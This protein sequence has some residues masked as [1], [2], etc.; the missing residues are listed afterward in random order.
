MI[1]AVN[2]MVLPKTGTVFNNSTIVAGST[3]GPMRSVNFEDVLDQT[4]EKEDTQIKQEDE[5]DNMNLSDYTTKNTST[6]SLTSELEDIFIRASQKYNVP[7]N[8]LKAVGKQESNFQNSAVSHAGAQGIM[9]LMP[10][11][12]QYLGVTD[13]FDPEQNIMGGAKYLSQMLEKFDNDVV[14]AL[15][16]YNAGPGSVTKYGG[17]PPYAETQDYVKKVTKYMQEDITISNQTNSSAKSTKETTSTA[18]Q[19]VTIID[20]TSYTLPVKIVGETEKKDESDITKTADATNQLKE[21]ESITNIEEID[22]EEE[23][24]DFVISDEIIDEGLE[25]MEDSIEEEF[26]V[27]KDDWQLPYMAMGFQTNVLLVN[28][29]N[30]NYIEE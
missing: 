6:D 17:V 11:T 30:K 21:E 22:L 4:I 23:D 3:P 13:P 7:L 10:G 26:V 27:S 14:L 28:S 1:R 18:S 16:A 24:M 8:L 20:K 2:D 25:D 29:L 5:I 15:A 9:Q 19:G 12:A